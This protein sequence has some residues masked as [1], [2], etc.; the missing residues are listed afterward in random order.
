LRLKHHG[1]VSKAN[2]N[3]RLMEDILR[4]DTKEGKHFKNQIE[5]EQR[6]RNREG[7]FVK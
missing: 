3:K 4:L 1:K 6:R 7:R 2:E 5:L